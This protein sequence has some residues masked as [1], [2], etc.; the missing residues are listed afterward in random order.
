MENVKV[1]KEISDTE[2]M[3]A[4]VE[5]NGKMSAVSEDKDKKSDF[6]AIKDTV[7]DIMNDLMDLEITKAMEKRDFA[8]I[9][10]M[11]FGADDSG[12]SEETKREVAF[13]ISEGLRLGENTRDGKF[14]EMPKVIQ[15]DNLDTTLEVDLRS[16]D[17]DSASSEAH[18]DT[19][20]SPEDHSVYSMQNIQDSESSNCDV[21]LPKIE[22]NVREDVS[23]ILE[24]TVVLPRIECCPRDDR[25]EVPDDVPVILP[26]IESHESST[27]DD[28]REKDAKNLEGHLE[29]VDC[30]DKSKKIGNFNVTK[31]EI[32]EHSDGTRIEIVE[33]F[34]TII[35]SKNSGENGKI[36]S[37]SFNQNSN[38]NINGV[39]EVKCESLKASIDI[40][41]NDEEK[42][43]EVKS[44]I[45]EEKSANNHKEGQGEIM[46]SNELC[47]QGEMKT[48]EIEEDEEEEEEEDIEALY[49]KI[50]QYL[51]AEKPKTIKGKVYDF[52]PK[53][54]RIR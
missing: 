46:E 3:D 52:D 10:S 41:T 39:D 32:E 2:Y 6:K 29:L 36:D 51:D 25:S 15:K 35:G 19:L 21:A 54:H 23:E 7:D 26:N 24:C 17:A 13:E 5:D 38:D 47:T 14:E 12:Q 27:C 40:K 43:T 1:R 48:E 45:F 16:I 42:I 49:N 37:F 8:S 33:T 9:V 31:S 4:E 34:E 11:N 18:K 22:P 28:S 20:A 30:Q 53:K 44:I 50:D